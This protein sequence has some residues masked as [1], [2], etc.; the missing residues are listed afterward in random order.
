MIVELFGLPTSGKT[1][2]ATRLVARLT[3]AGIESRLVTARE[4]AQIA[5]ILQR[6]SKLRA[7]LCA[8][9]FMP[10]SADAAWDLLVLFPQ[11]DR[12]R[13]IR[14]WQDLIQMR[15]LYASAAERAE[16][17]V[18]DQGFLQA[19]YSVAALSTSCSNESLAAALDKVPRS[20]LLVALDT[21][22]AI[23]AERLRICRSHGQLAD[24]LARD[25][26]ALSAS[27]ELSDRIRRVAEAGA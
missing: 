19:L 3:E 21:S 7:M 15:E 27:V 26:T 20:D 2:L 12:L 24:A 13:T 4:P 18:L 25:K 1:T 17:L 8:F 5:R 11:R 23:I 10:G 16:V 14:L 22:P 6:L 9:T